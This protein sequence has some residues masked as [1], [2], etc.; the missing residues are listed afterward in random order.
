M[1]CRLALVSVLIGA[2]AA[3]AEAQ[4]PPDFS[5]LEIKV[6][7]ILYVTDPGGVEVSGPLAARSPAAL[8]INGYT[9]Q[10]E[11]GLKIERRG[12]PIWDGALIGFGAGALIGGTIAAEACLHQPRWHC[13]VGGGV[14]YSAVGAFID[15]AHKGRTVI[16]D[17][18]LHALG[19]AA[20]YVFPVISPQQ[21]AIAVTLSFK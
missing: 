11:P 13:V 7:D 3:R 8:K 16:Y 5:R 6:G 10:P 21:K 2:G 15:W 4:P 14:G 12:D 20:R 17:A 18:R 19:R 9:F 1:R